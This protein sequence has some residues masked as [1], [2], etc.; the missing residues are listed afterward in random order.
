M[1]GRYITDERYNIIVIIIMSLHVIVC[2]VNAVDSMILFLLVL[3]LIWERLTFLHAMRVSL[4]SEQV[5]N[6][7]HTIT[8]NHR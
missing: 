7:F 6:I 5:F 3:F 8:N 1:N 4:N 2:T